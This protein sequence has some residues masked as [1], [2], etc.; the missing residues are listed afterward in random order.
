MEWKS[1][2]NFAFTAHTG[3]G[4]VYVCLKEADLIN[5]I[6]VHKPMEKS[7]W[8]HTHYSWKRES[9]GSVSSGLFPP[10][11][12]SGGRYMSDFLV[13][14]GPS[15]L[16][17]FF[18]CWFIFLQFISILGMVQDVFNV[19]FICQHSFYLDYG[20]LYE[21]WCIGYGSDDTDDYRIDRKEERVTG[22]TRR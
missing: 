1:S 16:V 3:C 18:Y 8:I 10:C 5:N 14:K 17:I 19:L 20:N 9:V 7:F 22:V 2:G 12:N 11:G 15:R 13:L 6:W 21:S 4:D